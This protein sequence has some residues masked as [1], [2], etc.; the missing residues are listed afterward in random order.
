MSAIKSTVRR[1][2]RPAYSLMVS[3][4]FLDSVTAMC[5]PAARSTAAWPGVALA[6]PPASGLPWWAPIAVSV[7]LVLIARAYVLWQRRGRT[8]DAP[9]AA[10]LGETPGPVA[11]DPQDP[12]VP[13]KLDLAPAQV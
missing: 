11:P 12:E 8:P 4:A 10:T 1:A 7:V 6:G 2:S 5:A 13:P 3:W 9:A